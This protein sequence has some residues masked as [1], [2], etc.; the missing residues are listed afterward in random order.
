[1]R[2][3]GGRL[4]VLA[5]EVQVVNTEQHTVHSLQETQYRYNQVSAL[6]NAVD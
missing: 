5:D 6:A 1:L 4:C 3:S 2:L